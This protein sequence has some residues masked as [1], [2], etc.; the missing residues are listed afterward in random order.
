MDAPGPAADGTRLALVLLR[1]STDGRGRPLTIKK[2]CTFSIESDLLERLRSIKA[3]TGMS[4]AEQIRQAIRSWLA[5][6]DWPVRPSRRRAQ[7]DQ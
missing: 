4:E 5:T 6:Q 1:R 7:L 2:R 3:R